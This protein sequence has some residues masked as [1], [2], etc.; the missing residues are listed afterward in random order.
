MSTIK[1]KS[2]GHIKVATH[3]GVFHA[4]DALAVAIVKG[5]T[6]CPLFVERTRNP[7]KIAEAD[8]VLDVGLVYDQSI[9][10]FDHH[11]KTGAGK[12]SS[13]VPFATAGLVWREYGENF[14]HQ[15]RGAN[16]L[17]QERI[18]EIVAEI[19]D[20][21]VSPVDAIDNAY[22]PK[23]IVGPENHKGG[24]SVWYSEG[25][26]ASDEFSI[27]SPKHPSCGYSISR[28]VSALNPIW[29][30]DLDID[31]QFDKA[32]SF[33]SETL[34]R[35]VK[36]K[37]CQAIAE[38]EVSAKITQDPVLVLDKYLPWQDAACE[39]DHLKFVVF[40][41][42]QGPNWMVQ[43]VP[44]KA[45]GFENRGGFPIVWGGQTEKALDSLTGDAVPEG[46]VFCHR[47]LF[48]AG[49]STKE[50]AIAMAYAAL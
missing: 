40:P 36:S 29:S 25:E 41:E 3:N 42:S 33:C 14:V 7:E 2:S 31:D 11:Q 12:R 48:I 23:L 38:K 21:I 1:H 35:A 9:Q 39:T 6:S 49:H 8:V 34:E 18:N 32:V 27:F 44:V 4:D 22:S 17:P 20:E 26:P 45:G 43:A 5:S 13:G 47:A 30:E 50:G 16:T 15:F 37:V 28:I 46:A 24:H 19:D 10:R